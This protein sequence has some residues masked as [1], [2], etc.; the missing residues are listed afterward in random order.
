VVVMGRARP[1]IVCGR[2][3]EG[4]SPRCELHKE[5]SGRLRPCLVCGRPSQGNYCTVH[6]PEVDE[7]VRN[8]RNPYRRHYKDPQYAKNRQ[9]RFERARGRCEACGV[10]LEAGGWQ[11]DHVVPVSRGGTNAIENLAILCLSCHSRKTAA[12]RRAR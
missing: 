10:H 6:R 4:G 1:C 8:E 11:C 9:H 2:R 3:V 5:G 12:D 7:A